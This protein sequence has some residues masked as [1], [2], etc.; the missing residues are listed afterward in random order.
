MKN[1]YPDIMTPT[2]NENDIFVPSCSPRFHFPRPSL[3]SNK[4]KFL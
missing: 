2:G 3:N 1:M 4:G